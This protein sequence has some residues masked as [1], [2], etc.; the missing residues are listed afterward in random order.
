M[1]NP[2]YRILT[3]TVDG[4]RRV[5]TS[6]KWRRFPDTLPL[7]VAEMD[8]APCEPVVQAVETAMRH[9]DTGYIMGAEYA[10]AYQSFAADRWGFDAG[11][12]DFVYPSDVMTGV[13]EGLR[14][15]TDPGGPVVISPPV[16]DSFYNDIASIGRTVVEAPLTPAGYRLDLD[17]LER[18]FAEQTATG[19]KVAYLLCNPHNPV[20]TVPTHDELAAL[21][22]LAGRFGVRV[23]SDEIHAPL[24]YS[25]S[26]FVPYLSAD[27]RGAALFSASKAWN[28]AGIKAALFMTVPGPQQHPGIPPAYRRGSSHLGVIAHT[29][30]MEQGRGWLDEVVHELDANRYLLADLLRESLPGVG[31]RV[32]DSTYLAW[33]DFSSLGLGPNPAVW[34]RTHAAVTLSPGAVFWPEHGAQFARLN[35][36]TSPE[37]LREAVQRIAASL[38]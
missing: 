14:A 10:E 27:P 6:V 20:G 33:L 3:A 2:T 9:G 12:L 8:A 15:V 7:W 29:A 16:Y 35:F 18:V 30:A 31:Y 11:G 17:A 25:G 22:G 1:P 4:E 26:S 32:P 23:I 38:G 5:R 34:L 36:A 24:V 13:M 37:I 28:L 21:A 19:A